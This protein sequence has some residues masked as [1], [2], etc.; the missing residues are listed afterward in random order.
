MT[1]HN[2]EDGDIHPVHHH[3]PA[4]VVCEVNARFFG[5]KLDKGLLRLGFQRQPI[6]A[7]RPAKSYPFV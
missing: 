6:Q 3:P 4:A 7:F 2:Q 1:G 5:L